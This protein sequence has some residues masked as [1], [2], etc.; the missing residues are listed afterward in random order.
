MLLSGCEVLVDWNQKRKTIN[1]QPKKKEKLNKKEQIQSVF[2]C[3]YYFLFFFLLEQHFFDLAWFFYIYFGLGRGERELFSPFICVFFF[4]FCLIEGRWIF[5]RFF[6]CFLIFLTIFGPHNFCSTPLLTQTASCPRHFFVS[7]HFWPKLLRTILETQK[8]FANGAVSAICCSCLV[9]LG[10]GPLCGDP[11]SC[12]V[13]CFKIFQ[14]LGAHPCFVA[15]APAGV[16]T[17]QNVSAAFCCLC[18]CLSCLCCFF[19]CFCC[20]LGL[21]CAV[22]CTTYFCLVRFVCAFCVVV[23]A[24]ASCVAFRVV[25]AAAFCCFCSAFGPPTVEPPLATFD[26]PKC[27]YCFCCF[28]CCFCHFWLLLD[29]DFSCQVLFF[30]A[31]FAAAFHGSLLLLLL[32]VVATAAG[33]FMQ[34]TVE[35]PILARF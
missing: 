26:L 4:F 11:P 8:T 18:C 5:L 35:K 1:Q 24:S 9:F 23:A 27:S 14:D 33:A 2:Y 21:V 19:C 28:L 3:Y 17:F 34:P 12:C 15:A 10:H 20:C 7:N 29:A 25:C 32:L 31:A 13:V 16:L 30:L 6:P 22:V